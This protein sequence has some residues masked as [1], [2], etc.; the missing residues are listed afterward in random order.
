M[1]QALGVGQEVHFDDPPVPRRDIGDRERLA[2][3]E[4]DGSDG[5]IDERDLDV[6]PDARVRLRLSGARR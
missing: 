1:S 6:E 2:V 4:R 5:P 3:A